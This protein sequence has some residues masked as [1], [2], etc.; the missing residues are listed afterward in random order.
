MVI[1]SPRLVAKLV[2]LNHPKIPQRSD[3]SVVGVRCTPSMQLKTNEGRRAMS[4]LVSA[5]GGSDNALLPWRIGLF[6][7]NVTNPLDAS[8]AAASTQVICRSQ[9]EMRASGADGWWLKWCH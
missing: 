3:L 2:W 1:T 7:R 9:S 4:Q 5:V 6:S 8:I